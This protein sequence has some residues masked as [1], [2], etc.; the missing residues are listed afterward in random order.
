M[1][2]LKHHYHFPSLALTARPVV[3][4]TVRDEE[5]ELIRDIDAQTDTH[6]D[7][8]TLEATPDSEVL[9]QRWS[10]IVED[11]EHDPEWQKFA[12]D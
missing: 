7:N 1:L 2:K 12:D 3:L 5:D 4:S 8:W 11:V 6:D 9:E 10:Q